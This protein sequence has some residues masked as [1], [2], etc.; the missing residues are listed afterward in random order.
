MSTTSVQILR[1]R[2]MSSSTSHKTTL[3]TIFVYIY[4]IT[5]LFPKIF[6]LVLSVSDLN[7]LA[8]L[9]LLYIFIFYVPFIIW[10]E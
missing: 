5:Y 4:I 6:L 1:K 7:Y 9:N 10:F 2:Y 3:Q 8:M